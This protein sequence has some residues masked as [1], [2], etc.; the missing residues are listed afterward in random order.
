MKTHVVVMLGMKGGTGKSTVAIHLAVAAYQA[1]RRV[2]L[3][4]TDPQATAL[5]WT[6]HRTASEPHVLGSPAYDA[7]KHIE[8]A[9]HDLV[10]VDTAPRAEADISKLAAQADLIV[11]PLHCTMP[12]LDATKVAF[13]MA[14]ASGRP[15]VIVFNAINPRGLEV[16]EVREALSGQGYTVA[17]T[18]L[19]HRTAFARA[20][21][22]G[23][24]VTEFEEEGRAA[25]EITNLWK[26]IS[27]RV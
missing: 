14:E 13:Q 20:F 11:I 24:A 17:P 10:V 26:W 9:E 4:D 27:K 6:R 8:A 15:F 22:S 3:L 21:S 16:A 1:K 25:E 2:L 7:P 12:D 18:M 5:R 19:A 23:L